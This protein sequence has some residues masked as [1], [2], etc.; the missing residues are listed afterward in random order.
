MLKKI[1]II[2]FVFLPIVLANDFSHHTSLIVD[3]NIDSEVNL[4]RV[5]NSKVDYF[6][7]RLNFFPKSDVYQTVESLD[8]FSTPSADIYENVE[9][10]KFRWNGDNSNLKYGLDARVKTRNVFRNI[11]K[12]VSFPFEY[13]EEE[14]LPY[15]EAREYTDIN[16]DIINKANEIVQG[17][18]DLFEAIYKIAEWT[19]KNIHYELGTLTEKSVQKSSWVL[20]KKFGVC[21]EI[22]NLFISLLRSLKIPVKY[23]SGIAY[24]DEIEAWSPHAWAEVYFP[25]AGWVPFD[26]TFGQYG[27]LDAG[28]IKMMEGYDANEPSIEYSWRAVNVNI[29][30]KKFEINTELK[31]T[32]QDFNPLVDLDLKLLENDVGEGSY[33]P[34]EVEL[35]NLQNFYVSTLVYVSS[36]PGIVDDNSKAILLKPYQMKKLYWIINLSQELD[37]GFMYTGDVI[38]QDSFG[39][40]SEEKLSFSKGLDVIDYNAAQT[41]LDNLVQKEG[42]VRAYDLDLICDSEKNAY[43]RDENLKIICFIKN[44]GNVPINFDLCFKDECKK[45]DLTINEEKNIDFVYSLENHNEQEQLFVKAFN[46]EFS[47]TDNVLFNVYDNPVFSIEDIKVD[48]IRYDEKGE[49]IIKVNAVPSIDVLNIEG[50]GDLK[51]ENIIGKQ[52]IKIPIKG[53]KFDEGNNFVNLKFSY[54]FNGKVYETEKGFSLN[55]EKV[56]FFKKLIT[57]LR[58]LFQ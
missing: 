38:V 18:E 17:E 42:S 26:V 58:G 41:R 2:F 37:S 49:V 14:N 11:E 57:N 1:L 30:S 44:K 15:I 27:W 7:A 46:S 39:A 4:N 53:W 5:D 33:V 3:V 34:I 52:E 8:F 9:D 16:Q 32:G 25:E 13:I 23:V 22:T 6:E 56:G 12:S 48:D 29:N 35:E 24:S 51:F 21:D 40:K 20:E 45:I 50:I 28:H 10:I 43:F 55:I 31:D 47:F 54:E 19:R 36:A